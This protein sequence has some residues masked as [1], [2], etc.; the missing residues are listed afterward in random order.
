MLSVFLGII[1]GCISVVVI[2]ITAYILII[3]IDT[4]IKQ[5]KKK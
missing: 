5:V 1:L 2:A 3:I 4:T